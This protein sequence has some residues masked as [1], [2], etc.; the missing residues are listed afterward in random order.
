MGSILNAVYSHYPDESVV[1]RA[2]VTHARRK[3][4]V[5]H[6]EKFGRVCKSLICGASDINLI[7]TDVGATNAV[8]APFAERGIEVMRV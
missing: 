8:I 6:H 1:N 7:I 3:V 5:T 4:V 2:M